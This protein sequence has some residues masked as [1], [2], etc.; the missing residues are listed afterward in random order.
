MA[1]FHGRSRN[2]SDLIVTIFAI[3]AI[4]L[5]GGI[6]IATIST[7]QQSQPMEA[8]NFDKQEPIVKAEQAAL[9]GL[10]AVRGHI[11]C[12]GI[13]EKGGLPDQYYANGARFSAVWDDINLNDSTVHVISTGYF[14]D[15]DG[16]MHSSK[17]ES[18]IKV[19]LASAHNEGILNNYYNRYYGGMEN[20]ADNQ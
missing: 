12:H 18:I 7:D 1:R 13:K 15:N 16:E 3:F 17:F 19:D 6:S 4:L 20:P 5:A 11:E 2:Q 10:M 8:V 14:G 9:A